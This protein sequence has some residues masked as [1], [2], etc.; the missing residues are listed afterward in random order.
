MPTAAV[1]SR[2]RQGERKSLGRER[3]RDREDEAASEGANVAISP[4]ANGPGGPSPT[5]IWTQPKTI[6]NK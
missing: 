1:T 6:K 4:G 5:S 3:G 2:R